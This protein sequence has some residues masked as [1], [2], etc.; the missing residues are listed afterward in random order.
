MQAPWVGNP[1]ESSESE[2]KCEHY[3]KDNADKNK[4]MGV[5]K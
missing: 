1:P 4:G 5:V 3:L 2:I